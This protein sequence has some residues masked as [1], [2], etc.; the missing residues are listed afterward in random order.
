MGILGGAQEDRNDGEKDHRVSADGGGSLEVFADERREKRGQTAG[1]GIA[2]N[3]RRE[4]KG[5]GHQQEKQ[6]RSRDRRGAAQGEKTQEGPDKQV[7]LSAEI[8]HGQRGQAQSASQ[9][10]AK[11]WAQI[12][13]GTV[14]G[15]GGKSIEILIPGIQGNAQRPADVV[16]GGLDIGVAKH[17]R[18]RRGYLMEAEGEERA[19]Q[20]VQ[21]LLAQPILPG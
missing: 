7:G 4:I 12:T 10:D 5:H 6:Q 15:R 16:D 20:S 19:P 9:A 13:G 3:G 1:E 18:K 2:G 11:A 17:F 14:V 8:K 21:V